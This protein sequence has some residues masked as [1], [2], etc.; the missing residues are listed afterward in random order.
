LRNRKLRNLLCLVLNCSDLLRWNNVEF[1]FFN[2]TEMSWLYLFL[3]NRII[4]KMSCSTQ[5]QLQFIFNFWT[6]F[7]VS[8]MLCAISENFSVIKCLYEF[9]S[10]SHHSIDSSF[11]FRIHSFQLITHS[12]QSSLKSAWSTDCIFFLS[13]ICCSHLILHNIKF[14]ISSFQKSHTFINNR[15]KRSKNMH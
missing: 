11:F 15:R 3:L 9:R 14:E 12:K 1:Y 5:N 10:D 13:L 4:I 6:H 2:V 7:D 8:L